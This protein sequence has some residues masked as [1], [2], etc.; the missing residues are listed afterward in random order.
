MKF[1]RVYTSIIREY[2]KLITAYNPIFA[3][4][5]FLKDIQDVPMYLK[6]Y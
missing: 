3:I 5:N 1:M 2:K 6:I 4:T